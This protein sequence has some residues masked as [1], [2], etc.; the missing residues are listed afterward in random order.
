MA[1]D[2]DR[3][4]SASHINAFE[5]LTPPFAGGA[6]DTPL[7]LDDTGASVEWSSRAPLLLAGLTRSLADR[8]CRSRSRSRAPRPRSRRLLKYEPFTEAGAF[9]PACL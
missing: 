4:R 9:L 6:E 5:H 7:P 2:A 1:V 8:A 3:A